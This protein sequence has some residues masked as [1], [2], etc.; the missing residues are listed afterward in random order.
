MVKRTILLVLMLLLAIPL[1]LMA[2]Q[3]SSVADR[4]QLAAGES[5][6]LE[7]RVLGSPDKDPDLSVLD[8][9][10]EIL[11]RSQSSQM[12]F[13]NGDFS[14]SVVYS[15]TLMPRRNGELEIPSICFGV[16]CSDSLQIQ[17]SNDAATAQ[18]GATLL[19]LEAEAEPQQVPAGAQVLLTVRVL[20]RVDLAQASLGEP[21]PEGV[22]TEVQKVG[23]DRSFNIHREGYLYQAIERRYA[24]FPQAAGTLRIPG[25]QLDAQIGSGTAQFDPFG[26][27]LKPVRRHSEPIDIRVELARDEHDWLPAKSVSLQDNWQGKVMH[28]TVGE[29]ATRTLTLSATGLP[30]ARL[31]ALPLT[32]PEDFK[33]YPDQP[34]RSDQPGEDG[35]TGTLQQKLALVATRPGDYRLPAIDIDWWDTAQQHWQKAHIPEVELTVAPAPGSAATELPQTPLQPSVTANT[36]TPPAAT[37]RPE[38]PPAPT[39]PEGTIAED[40]WLWLSLALAVGWLA[41]LT[42]FWR[43]RRCADATATNDEQATLLESEKRARK[44]LLQTARSNNPRATRQAL[45]S[46]SQTLWPEHKGNGLEQ[47]AVRC[48]EPLASE[49]TSLNQALYSASSEAWQGSSLMAAV[50]EWH[51]RQVPPTSQ[52]LPPLYPESRRQS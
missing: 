5:L 30:A 40:L 50:L 45:L 13:V 52:H 19:L 9:E 38:A 26:R 28:M 2:A 22:A 34:D 44:A 29:P 4:N 37:T 24:L 32:V 1:T 7:L 46:W 42:F 51:H 10:W 12:S 48:G 31:P 25:L 8:S 23:E 27:S 49:L 39:T 6:R 20:H 35:I 15:L 36:F 18:E 33:R 47:L 3:V 11:S 21:Q 41:T 16:D 43:K 14:R 17:V